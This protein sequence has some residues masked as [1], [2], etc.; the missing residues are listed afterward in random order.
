MDIP[1]AKYTTEVL[2]GK[3]TEGRTRLCSLS[4]LIFGVD[5]IEYLKSKVDLANI[6]AL[7]GM[8][9]QV[10]E[11]LASSQILLSKHESNQTR[12][13]KFNNQMRQKVY[14]ACRVRCIYQVLW[15]HASK[16]KGFIIP[17]KFLVEIE[18]ALVDYFC[19][20]LVVGKS[21]QARDDDGD[22]DNNRQDHSKKHSNS[23]RK[24]TTYMLMRS[25]KSHFDMIGD[26]KITY[27]QVINFFR[28]DC[29]LV[30]GWQNEIESF[31]LPQSRI[32]IELA[33]QLVDR[34]NKGVV[35]VTD[36]VKSLNTCTAATKVI[37]GGT[38]LQQLL[39]NCNNMD[40]PPGIEECESEC[41]EIHI[42]PI[43]LEETLVTYLMEVSIEDPIN[44]MKLHIYNLLGVMHMFAGKLAAAETNLK[45]AL[46][47]LN[48]LSLETEMIACK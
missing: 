12:S 11:H 47:I 42:T 46:Q 20:H 44:H 3:I 9:Q 30:M 35:N 45:F 31:I 28:K 24:Q 26:T 4:R 23:A 15:K 43:T 13:K 39:S 2:V 36:L 14:L 25:M 17:T 38:F 22:D 19:D 33:F 29:D 21:L 41:D 40:I 34:N 1:S 8:W 37:N 10:N 27:L 16:N 7:Q 18:A 48:E 6:Y 5:S 32:A